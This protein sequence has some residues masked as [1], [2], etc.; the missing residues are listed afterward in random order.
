MA[1]I[2]MEVTEQGQQFLVGRAKL[3]PK[4]IVETAREIV[5]AQVRDHLQSFNDPNAVRDY[6]RDYC[7]GLEQ[8]VFGCIYLD[9]QHRLLGVEELFRG[10]INA[11]PVYPREVVKSA[12]KHNAAAIILFHN[13]PSGVPEPSN[14]D[15][16]VTH[17]VKKALEVI[18]VALL[19]HFVV[20]NPSIASFA[21]RGLL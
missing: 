20:G 10:T 12:L 6:L 3:D 4:H 13:H 18:D 21:E 19:D 11:A 17:R 2:R 7:M 16:R 5:R 8:E 15:E 14:A 1:N 9:S